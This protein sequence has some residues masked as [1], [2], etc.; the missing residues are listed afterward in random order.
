[1]G[2]VNWR[3]EDVC[4]L[5]VWRWLGTR[6]ISIKEEVYGIFRFYRGRDLTER[7]CNY[8]RGLLRAHLT[9]RTLSS[10]SAKKKEAQSIYETS[11]ITLVPGW[12]PRSPLESYWCDLV[13]SPKL[14][15]CDVCRC[16]STSWFLPPLSCAGL[17]P[18]EWCCS[19]SGH[20]HHI[21]YFFYV[22][23]TSLEK[24]PTDCALLI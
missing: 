19:Y 1:M 21:D 22:S 11:D 16:G 8:E 6:P 13:E 23:P 2:S 12:T 15:G 18:T 4:K 7:I 5:T 17:Q 14:L 20:T 9:V 10:W 3:C 24:C